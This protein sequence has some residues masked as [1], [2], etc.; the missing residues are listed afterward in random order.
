LIRVQPGIARLQ[1]SRRH[2]ADHQNTNTRRDCDLIGAEDP[3]MN[4]GK[5]NMPATNI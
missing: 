4:A 3:S 2:D 5:M 1:L